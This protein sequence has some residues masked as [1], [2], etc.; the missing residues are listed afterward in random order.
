MC[1]A[2]NIT[3][4]CKPY[5]P[6][7]FIDVRSYTS[8]VW[9][10]TAQSV[11]SDSLRAGRSGKWI[12]VGARFSS[13]VQTCPAS[14]PASCTV[15]TGSISRGKRLRRGLNHTPPSSAEVKET[16]ELYLYSSSGPSRSVLERVLRFTVSSVQRDTGERA[17]TLGGHS[18]CYCEKRSHINTCLILN[19]Y[20]DTLSESRAFYLILCGLIIRGGYRRRMLWRLKKDE[21]R[22]RTIHKG[23]EGKQTYSSTLS[24]TSALDRVAG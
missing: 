7:I 21:V 3:S 5:G 15:R 23:P 19:G 8:N 2:G 14:H 9:A 20:Q 18:I 17:N 12:P 16:V 11:S 10:A 6:H 4:L 1:L 13:A 22:L 24:L